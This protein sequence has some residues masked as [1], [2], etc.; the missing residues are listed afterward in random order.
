MLH[1]LAY[2]SHQQQCY[3][4]NNLFCLFSFYNKISNNVVGFVLQQK[5]THSVKE[6]SELW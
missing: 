4:E 6:N 1:S 3:S 2:I 5:G